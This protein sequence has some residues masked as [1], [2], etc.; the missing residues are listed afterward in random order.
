MLQVSACEEPLARRRVQDLLAKQARSPGA[1]ADV[2]A[3]VSR[4]LFA[5]AAS[6]VGLD[7]R[8]NQAHGSLFCSLFCSFLLVNRPAVLTRS[9][10]SPGTPVLVEDRQTERLVH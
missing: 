7:R 9:Q 4:A 6:P 10:R 5:R 1:L 2:G 3:V 8:E